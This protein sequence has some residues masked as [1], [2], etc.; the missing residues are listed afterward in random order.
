MLTVDEIE[1]DNSNIF[2]DVSYWKKTISDNINSEII[3]RG[4]APFQTLDGP[5]VM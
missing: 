1:N 5:L 3:K 4:S 2:D